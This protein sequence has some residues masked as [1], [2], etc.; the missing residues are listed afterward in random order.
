VIEAKLKRACT[1]AN[2]AA[3]THDFSQWSRATGY[4]GEVLEPVQRSSLDTVS[5]VGRSIL[6]LC[7]ADGPWPPGPSE[8]GHPAAPSEFHCTCHRFSIPSI[9][10]G[11]RAARD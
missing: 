3:L 1:F 7:I 5:R 8:R 6:T 11:M 4:H 9:R 2:H 10:A